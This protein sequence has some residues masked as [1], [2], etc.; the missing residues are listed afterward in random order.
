LLLSSRGDVFATDSISPIIYFIPREK[1]EIELFLADPAFVNLQGLDFTPDKKQLFVAD[2]A[3]GIFLVDLKTKKTT[4]LSFAPNVTLLGID[5]LYLFRGSL[6]AVQNG[7]NPPRLA[8][9][10]LSKDLLRVE[11]LETIQANDPVFDEPTLGVL[12]KDTFY[13]IANSQWGAIDDKGQLA[14]ADKLKE[15]TVLKIKL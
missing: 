11:R 7:I 12:V 1:D 9:L 2:Y 10:R 3:K 8:R 14:A 4:A 6:I 13:L 15:P 5:G